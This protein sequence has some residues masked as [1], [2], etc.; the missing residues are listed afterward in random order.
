MLPAMPE[1]EHEIPNMPHLLTTAQVAEIIGCSRPTVVQWAELG[2]YGFPPPAIE[3]GPGCSKRWH[4]D[5][6]RDWL[7][8]IR[9]R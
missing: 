9:T 2:R 7:N 4:P 6:I 5:D 3:G 8:S 1:P